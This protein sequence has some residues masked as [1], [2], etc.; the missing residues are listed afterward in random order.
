MV[1]GRLAINKNTVLGELTAHLWSIYDL[2]NCNHNCFGKTNGLHVLRAT[3]TVKN[4]H[5]NL[6]LCS[7]EYAQVQS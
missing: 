6:L 5:Q 3:L 1:R 4:T 7:F 2:K